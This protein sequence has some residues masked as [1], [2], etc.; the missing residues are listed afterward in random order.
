MNNVREQ[1]HINQQV[2]PEHLHDT[3]EIPF[4]YS[5]FHL[6]LHTVYMP[7]T[8]RIGYIIR[9]VYIIYFFKLTSNMTYVRVGVVNRI[10]RSLLNESNT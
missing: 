1:N 7:Y 9:I 5:S 6:V 8:I 2:P 10:S 4:G 3:K